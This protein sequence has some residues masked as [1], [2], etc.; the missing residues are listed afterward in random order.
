MIAI[1]IL[2]TLLFSAVGFSRRVWGI[3]AKPYTTYREISVNPKPFELI[4]IGLLCLCYFA[5]AS[6]IRVSSF[7]LHL[8]TKE[9][10]VLGIGACIGFIVMVAFLKGVRVVLRGKGS[11]WGVITGWGYTLVPTVLWFFLTSILFVLFPPPRTESIKGITFSVFYLLI[12]IVLLFWKIELYYLTIRFGMKFDLGRIII[13]TIVLVPV[14]VL[15]TISMYRW[16]I[17]RVPF[18]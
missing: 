1:E 5:L 4:Y 8:L 6:V 7:R 9:F 18:L 2:T 13:V 3:I 10:V 16:G 12:T 15:Y 14:V 17:F 11:F